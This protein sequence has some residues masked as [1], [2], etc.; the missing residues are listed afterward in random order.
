MT[1]IDLSGLTLYEPVLYNISLAKLRDAIRFRTLTV[2]VD[3]MNLC[4]QIAPP[5]TQRSYH[6]MK[7]WEVFVSKY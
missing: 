3:R 5:Y 6:A 4:Q 2:C 1:A 7:I